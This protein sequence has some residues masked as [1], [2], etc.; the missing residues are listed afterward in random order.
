[1]ERPDES[2]LHDFPERLIGRL[3]ALPPHLR[4]MVEAMAPHLAGQ[5]DFD[6]A[7]PVRTKMELPDWRRLYTGGLK[8]YQNAAYLQEIKAM[9]EA[10]VKNLGGRVHRAD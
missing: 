3:Q 7:Q 1:M 6:K 9:A 5:L 2:S 4:E 10:E 8:Q